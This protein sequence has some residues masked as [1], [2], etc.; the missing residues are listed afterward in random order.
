MWWR[1][2]TCGERL[3]RGVVY[4][5]CIFYY[6][7]FFSPSPLG[8]LPFHKTI[9][10]TPELTGFS[11][12]YSTV[13]C[14]GLN[15][16]SWHAAKTAPNERQFFS[17]SQKTE[18][19]ACSFFFFSPLLYLRALDSDVCVRREDSSLISSKKRGEY[20]TLRMISDKIQ[21]ISKIRYFW[22]RPAKPKKM[23]M[24]T[25]AESRYFPVLFLLSTR[26]WQIAF[27]PEPHNLFAS[28][29]LGFFPLQLLYTIFTH[30]ASDLP[31]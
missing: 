11:F 1:K 6:F 26:A 12:I 23:S 18:G 13:R 7:R 5:S 15:V 29:S 17:G 30:R 9:L 10:V 16:I 20:C 2:G 31:E 4:K 21:R 27:C 28:I 14:I 8:P 3:K 22:T 19:W 24:N 25:C